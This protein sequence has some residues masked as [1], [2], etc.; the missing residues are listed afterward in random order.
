MDFTLAKGEDR[1]FVIIDP[2]NALNRPEDAKELILSMA[3]KIEAGPA[4]QPIPFSASGP[5]R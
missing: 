4:D 1:V 2:E 5:S 3:A